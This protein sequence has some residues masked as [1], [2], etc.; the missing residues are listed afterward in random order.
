MPK[1]KTHRGAAKRF[2]RTASGKLKRSKAFRRHI[3][4]KKDAKT[5]MQLRKAGMVSE[6]DA[7]RIAQLFPYL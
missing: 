4:T 7:R 5:K 1:M 2:K 6:G 3:L